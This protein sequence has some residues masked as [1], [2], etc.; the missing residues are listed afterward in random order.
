MPLSAIV[1][2]RPRATKTAKSTS[3]ARILLFPLFFL[4]FGL[5]WFSEFPEGGGLPS[6]LF[7]DIVGGFRWV[8]VVVILIFWTVL[9]AKLGVAHW[10]TPLFPR[11]LRL[12]LTGFFISIGVSLTYGALQGGT[13]LFFD[14]RNILLGSLFALTI[15]NLIGT[16]THN[17]RIACVALIASVF[18]KTLY[19][20][21]A[22]MTGRSDFQLLGVRIP[23]FDGPTLGNAVFVSVAALVIALGVKSFGKEVRFFFFF[24]SGVTTL[25][26]VVLSFR[27]SFWVQFVIAGLVAVALLRKRRL[28]ATALAM[29]LLIAAYVQLGPTF[30][31]RLLSL[32]PFNTSGAFTETNQDHVND[33]LDAWDVIKASPILGHG[34][35]RTYET[36]RINTWKAES[37][38]VHNAVLHVWL[39][40][41]LL[42]M[43]TFIGFH[44][45][46]FQWLLRLIRRLPNWSFEKGWLVATLGYLV[47]VFATGLT[48]VPWPYGSF[49]MAIVTLSLIAIAA[50]IAKDNPGSLSE[51]V[52]RSSML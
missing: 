28:A 11:R 42:G 48:F 49:Q 7:H 37:W 50:R 9:T 8:D 38:G 52:Q 3:P 19:L 13:E 43:V 29:F 2:D 30:G 5:A 15:Y 41:G 12:W 40:Y 17:L 39:R 24:S 26:L 10:E 32:D 4:L 27:R 36:D 22:F 46:L 1:E 47:G 21:F 51:N 18:V 14:W 6:P 35:G 45:S 33:V 34:L 20:L 16:S 44:I 25:L 23:V 31:Q